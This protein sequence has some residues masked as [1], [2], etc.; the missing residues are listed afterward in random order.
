METG[1]IFKLIPKIMKEIGAIGK[2]RQ[3][4]AAAGGYMFRGIDDVYAA[5]HKTLC[6]NGV[7]CTPVVV[8]KNAVERKTNSGKLMIHTTLT[9]RYTFYAQDGSS[10]DAVTV[11]EAM[12]T[13]DKS[14]NKAMSA[15]QKYAFLQIFCIPTAEPK[16]TE[17][18]SPEPI[19]QRSQPSNTQQP[20][21][22]DNI[23]KPDCPECG[24]VEA[25]I[26]GKKEYGGGWCCWKKHQ[27]N[28]G[29]GHTW[30]KVEKKKEPPA[31]VDPQV[32]QEMKI[33]R[34]EV[35][36]KLN[37]AY[38]AGLIAGMIPWLQ[39]KYNVAL[40]GVLGLD[41]LVDAKEQLTNLIGLGGGRC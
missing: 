14:C 2:N 5:A 20:T 17:N 40:I 11:G 1:D 12:D 37:E 18:E 30:G 36:D 13:S 3:S 6:G 26:P 15:A 33:L 41:A 10:F 35:G 21:S 8:D 24:N 38:K 28:P 19:D 32:E 39:E 16:D 9:I 7:F 22:I 4:P 29:C 34:G 31:T 23:N 27:G 25:V